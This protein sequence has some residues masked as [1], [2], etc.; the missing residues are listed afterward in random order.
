MLSKVERIGFVDP[1]TLTKYQNYAIERDTQNTFSV[2]LGAVSVNCNL[3]DVATSKKSLM[4]TF[5]MNEK[6]AEKILNKAKKQSV[7][8]NLIRKAK[9]SQSE[10]HKDVVKHKKKDRGA[11]Q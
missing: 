9:K 7:S 4:D 11:R 8:V 6:K 2:S 5:G 3:K 1:P 10:N